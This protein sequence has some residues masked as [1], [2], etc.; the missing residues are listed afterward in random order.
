VHGALMSSSRRDDGPGDSNARVALVTGGARGIGEATVRGLARAGWRV[1]F[2]YLQDENAASALVS[3]LR[4][5][6]AVRSDATRPADVESAFDNAES[7]GRVALLVNNVGATFK[8]ASLSSWTPDDIRRVLDVNL[9][10]TL[11]S[12]RVALD[13]WRDDAAGRAI[14]NVSSGAATSG[15][16]GEYIPYAAA[17]AG[18][19]ALTIGLAKETASLGVRVNAVAPGTTDT[20][21]HAAAGDPDRGARVAAMVPMGRI[22][23]P[24]EIADAIVWLSSDKASYVSGAVLRITGGV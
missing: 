15:A 17:K 3:G 14:V 4:G 5:V 16:P 12:C 1:C 13:R 21:I 22:A 7:L 10:S 23:T 18:V 11:L 19:D 20:Q 6:T 24:A 2:T 8:V 9:Y